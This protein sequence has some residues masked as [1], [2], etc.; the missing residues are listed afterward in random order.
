MSTVAVQSY[1]K[2]LKM[3]HF[4]AKISVS[5]VVEIQPV[6]K[7]SLFKFLALRFFYLM[8]HLKWYYFHQVPLF[9][10]HRFHKKKINNCIIKKIGQTSKS[11][12]LHYLKSYFCGDQGCKNRNSHGITK[13]RDWL[14][15]TTTN[16]TAAARVVI[17]LLRIAVLQ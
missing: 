7:Q 9:R 2:L 15:K 12:L 17:V 16:K 3:L 14:L 10:K 8:K 1:L 6:S 13:S 5:N 11:V 4:L